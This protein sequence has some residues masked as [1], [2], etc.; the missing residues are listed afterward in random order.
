MIIRTE[1]VRIMTN[2][3]PCP[4]KLKINKAFKGSSKTPKKFRI[5]TC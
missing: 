1:M 4:G 3:E 2:N 5:L